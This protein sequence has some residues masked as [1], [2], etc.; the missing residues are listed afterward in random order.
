MSGSPETEWYRFGDG[1]LGVCSEDVPFRDRFRTV[2]AE[3]ATRDEV[4]ETSPRVLC[5]V[6]K[7]R[8]AGLTVVHFDDPQPL[9]AARFATTLFEDRTYTVGGHS[10]GWSIVGLA[11]AEHG[12]AFRGPTA[13]AEPES[14]WQAL[15]GNLAVNRVLRLQ[16]DVLFLHAASVVIEGKGAILTAPKLGGKTTLSTALAARG[17][18]FLGD[19]LAAVR[20]SDRGMLPFRRAISFRE[21]PR[22]AAVDA[23]LQRDPEPT[24]EEYPDGEPRR[25]ALARDLFPEAPAPAASLEAIFVLR[26]LADR[27]TVERFLPSAGDARLLAPF[28]SSLWS[29]PEA[30]RAIR[31]GAM[32][33]ATACFHVDAGTPDETADLI[34]RT[35]EDGWH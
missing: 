11:G 15:L 12:I 20:M 19:E 29:V 33:A 16:S 13:L 9:D 27:A 24:L 2:F 21:G 14:G 5:T 22:S 25:R 4:T 6:S 18:G 3:C 28:P 1:L 8:P 10:H 26:S 34:E 35:M 7:A 31:M 17:H 23:A 32:M 30:L